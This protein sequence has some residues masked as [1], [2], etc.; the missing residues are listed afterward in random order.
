LVNEDHRIIEAN[1]RAIEAYGYSL[2]ELRQK[3]MIDLVSSAMQPLYAERIGRVAEGVPLLCESEHQR[4]D[5][6]TFPVEVSARLIEFEGHRCAQSIVRDITERKRA[7]AEQ[8][9]LE[10]TLASIFE[11]SP[12]SM[13]ISDEKG[14]FLRQNQA[15]RE[16]LRITDEDVVGVYNLFN[17]PITQAA[18][19]VP[20]IEKV[21][22]EG[23]AVHFPLTYDISWL[24][25]PRPE[26]AELLHLEVTIAPIKD[27]WGLV[28]N[29]V[30]QHIDMTQRVHAEE[31]QRRTD[32]MLASIF[33][34]SPLS[35]WLADN[36]GM[37]IR[38]NQACRNLFHIRDE[39]VAER[40]SLFTDPI[41]IEAGVIDQIERVFREG[42]IA[43]FHLT[44]DVSRIRQQ[45]SE[46][47]IL[48]LDVTISPIKDELG[49]VTNAIVQHVNLTDKVRAEAEQQ[50][51][52][53]MLAS[54]FEQSPLPMWISDAQGHFIRQNPAHR[55]LFGVPDEELVGQF[56]VLESETFHGQRLRPLVDSVYHD[57]AI[58]R[59][60]I[61]YDVARRTG[62]GID[63]TSPNVV[64]VDVTVSPV[65]DEHG[66][67]V[68][69]VYQTIDITEQKR[70][71]EA[72]HALNAELE[73][74]VSERTAQLQAANKELESFA[75]SVSH[76]LRTPLRSLDGFS[77]ALLDDFSDRLDDVGRDYLLRIRAAAQ[78]MA[79]LI[80]D[81]LRLSRLTRTDMTLG[82]VDLSRLAEGI[83][84]ELRQAEPGRSVTV[85][86]QPDMVAQCDAELMRIVLAN[87]L[88]NA[89]KFTGNLATAHIAFMAQQQDGQTVY[90]VRDDGAGFDMAYAEKL[91]GVFQ[92]LHSG[93]EFP[94]TG[95]GLATV[96][97]IISRHGGTIWA[98]AA[99]DCG[100]T[101]FFTLSGR[102]TETLEQL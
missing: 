96:Q 19:V 18:G 77:L 81:L 62:V 3:R 11:Q 6:T 10:R 9:R 46:S 7:E 71:E 34:Q 4:K 66:V 58:A 84:E 55:D 20:L 41:C 97:R 90:L 72:L 51:V 76:D 27:E 23:V 47:T 83:V 56:N 2:E 78:R 88:G 67:V 32:R 45:P 21:F 43:R 31:N 15:C 52:E 80:D 102:P 73:Q 74:R 64:W 36:K 5:G 25:S 40:Y 35:M 99:V 94:G 75:Y 91:F 26:A 98:E 37:F 17:D 16:L 24:R 48:Y 22:R 50:Q 93:T 38:Q 14:T 100:A 79:R 65:K 61:V 82:P 44:Y 13:W 89:W 60:T 69:A 57:G 101:F 63:I 85:T 95:I 12:L 92:R 54:I 33:E 87:L 59:F 1:D 29:A 42:E 8:H 49:R 28:T 70:A 30:V 39:E 86:I 53:R 68:N